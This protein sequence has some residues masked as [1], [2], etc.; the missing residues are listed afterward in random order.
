MSTVDLPQL[1]TLAIQLSA[2]GVAELA[3]NRPQRYN[4]LSPEAY[5]DW[6]KA[7]QW[8]ASCDRVKVAVLTGRGKYYTSGQELRRPDLSA[9]GQDAQVRKLDV[10]KT[11]VDELIKF[12]KLLI[13]AVNGPAFGFG[14]TTLALCDVVYSVPHATFNTPF[15]K[16][17]YCAEGCSSVLF[18]RIMGPSK[19][20]EML[21]MGRTFTAEELERCGLISRIFPAENFLQTVLTIAEDCA[22]F[23][24][25]AMKI[26]KELI[27]GIDRDLLLEVNAREMQQLLERMRSQNAIDTLNQF[28]DGV[29][30][31]RAMKKAKPS[32]L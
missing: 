32:K 13:A 2:T 29:E 24:V 5:K 11:L 16:L 9:V 12:P 22:K 20:N 14:V 19:A 23:S 21:L 15:M 3:F 27:R 28:V 6:L 4:A 17:A 18:P 30:R 7:I 1:E 10:T 25:D 31:K 8:A 26:T